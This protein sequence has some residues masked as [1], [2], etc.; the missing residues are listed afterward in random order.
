MKIE[1]ITL[2]NFRQYIGTQTI[3]FSTDENKRVTV[4]VGDNTSGKTTLIRAFEWCLYRKNGFDNPILLN[5]EV[6]KQME[7]SETQDVI[8]TIILRNREQTDEGFC[9][10]RYKI[11]RAQKYICV[12]KD[13]DSTGNITNNISESGQMKGTIERLGSDGQTISSV[14]P[15]LVR[16]VID[17]ILPEDLSPYFFVT[18]ERLGAITDNADLKSS[19]RGLMGIDIL[20]NS[21]RHLRKIVNDY[22]GSL[23]K[24]GNVDVENAQSTKETK[25]KQLEAI[26]KEIDDLKDAISFYDNQKMECAANIKKNQAAIDDQKRREQ[27]E[28]LLIDLERDT[29]SAKANVVSAFNSPNAYAFF[30]RPLKG[31]VMYLGYQLITL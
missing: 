23:K 28:K 18:G 20:E 21:R 11:T 8:V 27:L 30:L 25:Q 19:V 15:G 9:D 1:S 31:K 22:N 10:V 4:L 17:G 29:N 5:D 2:H 14:D 13:Y 3:E 12:K 6:A 24:S 26:D 7:E 16:T